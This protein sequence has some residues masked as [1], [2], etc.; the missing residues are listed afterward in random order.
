MWSSTVV[1][2]PVELEHD[3]G[4]AVR[5]RRRG[6][7]ERAQVPGQVFRECQIRPTM[8]EGVHVEDDGPETSLTSRPRRRSAG[9]VLLA[10]L[11]GGTVAVCSVPA[12]AFR[13]AP[14]AS[15]RAVWPRLRRSRGARAGSGG[16]RG[17]RRRRSRS[18]VCAGQLYLGCSRCAARAAAARS[19][20][21]RT[22]PAQRAPCLPARLPDEPGEPEDGHVRVAFLP[23]FMDRGLGCVPLQ[24]A[25]LGAIFV[26]FEVLAGGTAG[27]TAGRPGTWRP[28]RRRAAGGRRP[29]RNGH[30]CAGRLVPGR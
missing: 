3:C 2:D 4:N 17:P 14:A 16:L 13:S 7:I 20:N 12:P 6:Q 22:A 5:D 18:F 30:G 10:Y 8:A 27:L 23:R 29:L 9:G 11:G 28:R 15:A 26:A 19:P 25:I 21:R 1:C 24:F